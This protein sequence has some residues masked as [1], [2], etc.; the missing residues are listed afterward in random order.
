MTAELVSELL[1]AFEDA[2]VPVWVGGGWGVDALVGRQSRPHRD[3]DIMY[4]I[5]QDPQVRQVLRE[6]GYEKDTDW[7]PVRVEFVGRSY[8]DTHPLQFAPDGSA[9]Q[10][11][12]DGEE[13][14]YPASAFTRGRVNGR[15]VR[16]LSVEQQLTFH[17]GY[18]PRDVD[19]H[20]LALLNGL[21]SDP[22]G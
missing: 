21:L 13:F 20:D 22:E 10:S 15:L 19:H 2:G 9:V 17:S 6:H 5:E 1:T 8:V 7:W 4:P 11:G 14:L 3:L 12:L 18:E 16:C